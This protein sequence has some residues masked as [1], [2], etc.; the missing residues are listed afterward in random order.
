[1][2]DLFYTL[3]NIISRDIINLRGMGSVKFKQET[4]GLNKLKTIPKGLRIIW[5]NC[6][7]LELV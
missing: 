2:I 6:F 5:N 3:F 1:M 4:N 7:G